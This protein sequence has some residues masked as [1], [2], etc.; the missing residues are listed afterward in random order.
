MK[1]V[2]V[3][4]LAKNISEI[5]LTDDEFATLISTKKINNYKGETKLNF[6]EEIENIIFDKIDNNLWDD[7]IIKSVVELNEETK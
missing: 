5:Q 7:L 3:T 4:L 1:T 2:R 6:S